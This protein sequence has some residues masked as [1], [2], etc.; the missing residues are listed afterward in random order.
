MAT[1]VAS[2]A[3]KSPTAQKAVEEGISFAKQNPK[4]ILGVM[5]LPSII[6][7]SLIVIVLIIAAIIII[8]IISKISGYKPDVALSLPSTYEQKRK[9]IIDQPYAA[10][11]L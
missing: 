8:V 10:F 2:E 9:A 1:L 6:I 4:T 3:L 5:L 7:F 11:S